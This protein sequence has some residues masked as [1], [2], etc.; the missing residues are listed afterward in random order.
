M[1]GHKKG[2]GIHSPFVFDLVSRVFRNKTNSDIVNRIEKVRKRLIKD[3]RL[4]KVSDLGAGSVKMKSEYRKVSDIAKYS[5]VTKKYG[6]FLSNMASEFGKG[7]IIEFGTSF[8]ISTMY[9]AASVPED[10]IYTMEG[11]PAIAEIAKANFASEGFRNT[12]VMIGSFDELMPEIIKKGVKPGMIFID[13]NH[14][15]KPVLEYFNKMVEISDSET[16]IIIDDIYNS[17][18][19]AEAWSEIKL[20]QK[21]SVSIDVFRMGIVFFKKGIIRQDFIISH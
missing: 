5:P 21:V 8:G 2:H 9:M 1:S 13:G 18:E 20:N 17:R 16:V 4:I 7:G 11:S 3:R 15:K 10:I 12:K 14:R 19:M 6:I